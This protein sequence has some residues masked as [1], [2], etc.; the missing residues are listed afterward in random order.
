VIAISLLH[1]V[2]G[3]PDCDRQ[4]RVSLSETLRSSAGQG[5][6]YTEFL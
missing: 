6:R 3:R 1:L 4:N 2:A 5:N